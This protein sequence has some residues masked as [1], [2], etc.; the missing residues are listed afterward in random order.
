MFQQHNL[1]SFADPKKRSRSCFKIFAFFIGSA[2]TVCGAVIDYSADVEL[3][4]IPV[5]LP[6]GETTLGNALKVVEEQTEYS[7]TYITT[8]VPLEKMI[9]LS[10]DTLSLSDTLYT[11]SEGADVVFE[12]ING[13]ISV[14]MKTDADE[15]VR[16][17]TLVDEGDPAGSAATMVEGFSMQTQ[18][19]QSQRDQLSM[20]Q[21]VNAGMMTFLSTEDMS[22]FGG[23][24]LSDVVNRM[25]GVN[26]VEGRFA[27]VR[28]LGDRYISTLVNGLP[29]PSPDPLRQGVQLDLFSTA[30]IDKVVTHKNAL[31][32]MPMNSSGAAFELHTKGFTDEPSAWF[33]VGYSM[34]SNA[35]NKFLRNSNSA[36]YNF[37][38][39]G[40]GSFDSM[41]DRTTNIQT[42]NK[43]VGVTLGD[44]PLTPNFELGMSDAFEYWG[45]R[46]V[47]ILFSASYDSSAKTSEGWEQDRIIGSGSYRPGY[48]SNSGSLYNREMPGYG[49][50]YDLT[51]SESSVLL[52]GLAGVA[53]E[54][55]EEGN[56]E[57]RF[58]TLYSQNANTRAQRKANGQLTHEQAEATRKLE[59]ESGPYLKIPEIP[60]YQSHASG[61]RGRYFEG[62]IGWG[63]GDYMTLGNDISIYEERSLAA[64]QL[65]GDHRFEALDNLKMSWGISY[66]KTTSDSPSQTN[67]NYLYNTDNGHY[68]WG[69]SQDMEYSPTTLA[70]QQTWTQITEDMVGGRVD[71]DYSFRSWNSKDIRLQSGLFYSSTKRDTNQ[72]DLY[73]YVNRT[74]STPDF[75]E[76]MRQVF[77]YAKGHGNNRYPTLSTSSANVDRS[78]SAA[79]VMATLPFLEN[80]SFTGGVRFEHL[81]MRSEGQAQL[82]NSMPLNTFLNAKP[83]PWM[84]SIG[85][86]IGFT[87]AAKVGTFRKD[88]ILPSGVLSWN[89][90]DDLVMRFGGSHTVALPSLREMS[91]YMSLDSDFNLILGNPNLK[92]SDIYAAETR[93]EYYFESGGMV[94][95]SGFYK[96]IN[97]PIERIR[98]RGGQS[99]GIGDFDT[100]WNS[101]ET[102]QVLGYE[103][104]ARHHL[105][106]I[107]EEL[108]YISIGANWSQ[109]EAWVPISDAIRN[110]Y[111]INSGGMWYGPGTGP[112]GIRI[113]KNNRLYD[114]PK[115]TANADISWVHPDWGTGITLMVY[116]QSD[117]LSSVGGGVSLT[118]DE[119]TLPYYELNLAI[120]QRLWDNWSMKFSISNL[121]DTERGIKYS[122]VWVDNPATKRSYKVGQTY[123]I[124]VEYKF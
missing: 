111:A 90:T 37:F 59:R 87:D 80:L 118:V 15:I 103:L 9:S 78:H 41:P 120:T 102:A 97:N 21:K 14:R 39:F 93:L 25:V 92:P 51:R 124:S 42:L 28:G 55:D 8:E 88:Y 54:L 1:A 72:R 29:M 91:P 114:Q 4:E 74:I 13:K 36:A 45:K 101:P 96:R 104:E 50:H 2:I 99:S 89:I 100:F 65:G 26:V 84:P 70:L 117:V 75:D 19:F 56:H 67:F 58:T 46:K 73:Y 12:R 10:G 113:P 109:I 17:A 63:N 123:G 27:V 107:A 71:F 83:F 60:G 22:K 6:D 16:P 35:Q 112:D 110:T 20:E 18:Q 116:A 43:N 98:W 86:V 122:D 57:I 40:K 7:F 95:L 44:A 49:L 94:S 23:S 31:P 69:P 68:Q 11:L 121:T 76:Y 81:D 61:G 38:P 119:Y 77:Q 105:G 33:K 24:D 48:P 66:N 85:Q 108:K 64:F 106:F 62:I 53:F 79:Y 30:I 3:T 34:N 47:K 115:W 52:G 32:N 82:V 5:K